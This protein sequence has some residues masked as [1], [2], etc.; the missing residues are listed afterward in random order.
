MQ[1]VRKIFHRYGWKKNKQVFQCLKF[2]LTKNL[3]NCSLVFD[4][5]SKKNVTGWKICYDSWSSRAGEDSLNFIA[6]YFFH[7]SKLSRKFNLK[8]THVVF[9]KPPSVVHE[10]ED[11][12]RQENK[13]ERIRNCCWSFKKLLQLHMLIFW[14]ISL[15]KQRNRCGALPIYLKV[16]ARFHL[17][18]F[19]AKKTVLTREKGK[20]ANTEERAKKKEKQLFR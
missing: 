14:I 20:R 11:T 16:V 7:R 4:D 15:Q 6:T 2:S 19:F 18:S 13:L 1:A 10:F 5:S 12:G 9:L 3:R 8:K 17:Y